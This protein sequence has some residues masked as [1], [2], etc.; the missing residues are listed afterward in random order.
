M[1]TIVITFCTFFLLVFTSCSFAQK[2]ESENPNVSLDQNDKAKCALRFEDFPA[3]ATPEESFTKTID[4]ST[5]PDALWFK[6]KIT[7][8]IKNGVNFAG[9]YTFAQWGC[10]SGCLEAAIIDARD[11]RVST[12]GILS[13]NLGYPAY[14]PDGSEVFSFSF[15]KD[16]RLL[17]IHNLCFEGDYD[18]PLCNKTET[19]GYYELT[20]DGKIELKCSEPNTNVPEWAR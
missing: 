8:A 10:G 9:H 2:E 13:E 14:A 15:K 4:F 11:G 7:E 6:T 18:N 3:T 12:F 20:G 19:L 16:S 5:N 1:K 17:L